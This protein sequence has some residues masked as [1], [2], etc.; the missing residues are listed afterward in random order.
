MS[1]ELFNSYLWNIRQVFESNMFTVPVYQRPYSWETKH[2]K[3]LLDDLFQAYNREKEKKGTDYFIGSIY[4]HDLQDKLEGQYSK[5]DIIDG[6]QRLTTLTFLLLS[7]YALACEKNIS[8]SNPKYMQIKGSLWKYT[9]KYDKKN[10]VMALNSIEKKCFADLFNRCFNDDS[11]K[12]TLAVTSEKILEFLESYKP[13]S[14][15]DQRVLENFKIVFQ[16]VRNCFLSAPDESLIN[17]ATFLL[18]HVQV[19]AIIYKDAVSK[20]F[21]IFESMNSK[22]KILEEIDKIKTFIFSKFSENNQDYKLCLDEWGSLIIATNDRLYDYISNYIR[23]NI[24]FYGRDIKVED[25]KKLCEED[26]LTYTK[27]ENISSALATFINNL[28]L[29]VDY[30][31]MLENPNDAYRLVQNSEFR[32]YFTIFSQLEYRHPKALFF[33]CLK[34]YADGKLKKEDLTAI[35]REVVKFM[36]GFSSI[37]NKS[38]KSIV[39][40]FSTIM[41]DIHKRKVID[42]ESIVNIIANEIQRKLTVDS[43]KNELKNMDSYKNKPL[44]AALLAL[45]EATEIDNEGRAKISYDMAYQLFESYGQV[46][47]LD[48]L[49]VRTPEINDEN[50]KYYC[51]DNGHVVLKDGHDFDSTLA[52]TDYKDF[53]SKVLNKIGN[54]RLLYGDKNSSRQNEYNGFSTYNQIC[55][56]SEKIA[57]IIF[58]KCWQFP[59]YNPNLK[60]PIN[61]KKEK[62]PRMK[63]LINEGIINIGDKIYLKNAPEISEAILIDKSHVEC[64]GEKMKL[65]DWGKKFTGWPS[66]RIYDYLCIVGEE[67]TL[68]QKRVKYMVSKEKEE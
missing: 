36:V 29:D 20:A 24:K 45:Y 50:F 3:V 52:G 15:F 11:D 53:T 38:S 42:K 16:R 5:Y 31:K 54:L 4:I 33:R 40:M 13:A 48:H 2:V 44:A 55:L 41:S 68:Q 57:N 63:E 19:I 43:V 64:H 28:Y 59:V 8:P 47:D 46:L 12:E 66:I 56:R 18:E 49:L 58:D 51:D 21:A 34:E 62:L 1:T 22:G 25:F 10:C 9:T 30:Y 23:S 67:E 35:I 14:V 6:Q 26:L 65:N 61:S 7:I 32:F 37:S 27:T 39:P 17:F 60:S